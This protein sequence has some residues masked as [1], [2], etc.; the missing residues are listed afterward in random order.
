MN[1]LERQLTA[2][3]KRLSE[4]YETEQRRHSEQVEALRRHV[5]RLSGENDTLRRQTERLNGQVTRLTEYYGTSA[6]AR[7]RGHGW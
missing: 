3:L 7:P 5:E 2:A 6:A 4:Q 1:E